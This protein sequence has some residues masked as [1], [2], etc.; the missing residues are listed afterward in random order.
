LCFGIALLS[1]VIS[2]GL[3]PRSR[4]AGSV[5]YATDGWLRGGVPLAASGPGF[6]RARRDD[7]TRWAVPRLRA[8]LMRVARTVERAFPG[9]APLVI[10][11]LSARDGG[12]HAR[13]GSHRTGRDADLLFYL[14]D[15]DGRPQRGSGFFAFDERGVGAAVLPGARARGVAMFD[16]ARNW[17]LVRALVRDAEAPVQWIFC[18]DGIK[19]KLLAHAA[20][21]EPDARALV[22]AAYVLHQPSSGN[23]HRDHFHV[24][25]ACTGE[26]RAAAC[27]D[28]GPLWPWHRNEHEKPERGGSDDDASLLRA[29]LSDADD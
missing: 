6:V 2:C 9:G 14:R 4:E 11:D 12:G 7:D 28:D 16:V 29:L 18:A 15:I 17:A 20:R 13:H 24:R 3:A 8:L 27:L 10:G 5:G 26:E 21:H 1:L 23:P 22:R 25:I 19:A